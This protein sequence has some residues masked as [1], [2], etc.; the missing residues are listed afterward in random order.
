MQKEYRVPAT[1]LKKEHFTV[2]TASDAADF[3]RV[4]KNLARHA[5][6]NFKQG[7]ASTQKAIET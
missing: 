2:E 7:M 6:V 4:Q 5:G 1:V 3:K